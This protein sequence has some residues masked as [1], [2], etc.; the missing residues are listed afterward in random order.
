[1]GQSHGIRL[2]DARRKWVTLNVRRETHGFRRD[3]RSLQGGRLWLEEPER[4]V[5]W[6][7]T[8]GSVNQSHRGKEGPN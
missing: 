1:M 2:G 5:D 8:W 7:T 4:D 3:C 6:G